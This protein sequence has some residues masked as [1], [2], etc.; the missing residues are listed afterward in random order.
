MKSSL[1][2]IVQLVNLVLPLACIA[3]SFNTINPVPSRMQIMP[4]ATCVF[5]RRSKTQAN[6]DE[7]V[8]VAESIASLAPGNTTRVLHRHPRRILRTI[9]LAPQQ[10][11]P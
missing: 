7:L 5:V 2:D 8:G 4:R 3:V 9:H 6:H 10:R 1:T 11:I